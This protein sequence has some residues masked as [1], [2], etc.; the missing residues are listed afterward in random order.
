MLWE[1]VS[2]K[3]LFPTIKGK[4]ELTRHV[5]SGCRPALEP[6]W[7]VSLQE[8]L[9]LCWHQD[10]DKRPYFPQILKKYEQV[11]TDMLCPDN[12]G[13]KVIK[14]L[15]RGKITSVRAMHLLLI[16]DRTNGSIFFRAVIWAEEHKGVVPGLWESVHRVPQTRLLAHKEDSFE[17]LQRRALR[18]IWRH[19][20][21]WPILSRRFAVWSAAARWRV[22]CAHQRRV[23]TALL[24]RLFQRVQSRDIGEESLGS[25]IDET[26]LLL[27]PL[28]FNRS[29]W[30]DTDLHW[31]E[32]WDLSQKDHADRAGLQSWRHP[33]WTPLVL[34][35]A[36]G[37]QDRIQTQEVCAWKSVQCA[38]QDKI[39]LGTATNTP[40]LI[41]KHPCIII[42]ARR[43]WLFISQTTHPTQIIPLELIIARHPC[44][45]VLLVQK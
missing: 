17:V 27:V 18:F 6:D 28:Q 5:L 38:V 45:A 44:L 1:L 11:V 32:R 22:L 31:Q 25:N 33:R 9:A 40:V 34:E 36:Q 7:P 8:L 20:H 26:T 30:S 16:C 15:W 24:P 37:L 39:R 23:V 10:L 21:F 3:Q 19:N 29:D 2:L 41:A 35:G 43:W 42:M 4:E 14:R 12:V 13:K